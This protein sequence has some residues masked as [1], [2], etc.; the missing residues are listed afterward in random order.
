MQGWR[1][2]R[3][4]ASTLIERS[5]DEAKH[6]N[7]VQIPPRRQ[8]PTI[9]TH[10]YIFAC[11]STPPL[12]VEAYLLSYAFCGFCEPVEPS[13]LLDGSC[14]CACCDCDPK[15]NRALAGDAEL[16]LLLLERPLSTLMPAVAGAAPDDDADD[17][18]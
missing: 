13:A 8:R 1:R 16:L 17:A 14:A 5:H 4:G 11:T 3:A 10:L 18:P 6:Q 12:A 2:V 15:P 7:A 9:T